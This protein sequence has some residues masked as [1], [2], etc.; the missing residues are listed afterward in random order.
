MYKNEFDNALKQNK[1]FDA[2][3]FFG[4]SNYLIEY[5]A[6]LVAK[7]HTQS[8]DEIEKIY[9]D[10]F[11][12]NYVKDKLLQSSLF[13]SNNIVLVKTEKKLN[14]NDTMSLI[15]A[16][17]TNPD[18]VIIFACM[19][20]GDFKLMSS[21]FS[22]KTNSVSVRLYPPF[23]NEAIYM[24]KQKAQELSLN[25]DHSAI[26]HLYF[27]HNQNLS[28]CISDLQ[29]L[30]I[31]NEQITQKMVDFHCFGM[32]NITIDEFLI[33]LFSNQ[34]IK[35]DL[36]RMFEEGINEIQLINRIIDF[37]QQLIMIIS[38]MK[39]E[40]R[41]SLKDVLG[42]TLPKNIEA[43]RIQLAQKFTLEQYNT[44]L[45]TLQTLELD[46]KSG[47]TIDQAT[48]VQVALEKFSLIR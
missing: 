39:L 22:V 37:I 33:K 47:K 14:K 21:Y 1:K 13:S 48:Y 34:S 24:L 41:F 43:K 40:G 32:G 25:I 8:S 9:F 16:C 17:N 27:M 15:E 10:E 45:E 38:Y 5:Y 26:T 2:Y 12:I 11:D 6:D 18:S 35:N 4:Q 20:D 30:S 44:M 29:K 42:Y 23:D 3:M 31:L 46:L 28:F 7:N 36:S 19:G